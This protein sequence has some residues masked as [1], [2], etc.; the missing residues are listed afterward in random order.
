MPQ[1]AI[2]AAFTVNVNM[3]LGSVEFTQVMYLTHLW[4][5]CDQALI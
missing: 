4:L 3:M 5:E 2:P 1:L